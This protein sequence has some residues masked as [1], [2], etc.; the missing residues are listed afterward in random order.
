M[1]ILISSVVAAPPSHGLRFERGS[2]GVTSQNPFQS[3]P[4]CSLSLIAWEHGITHTHTLSLSWCSHDAVF[5]SS[6]RILRCII[7]LFLC[8]CPFFLCSGGKEGGI[9]GEGRAGVKEEKFRRSSPGFS[10]CFSFLFA[11]G[12]ILRPTGTP[13]PPLS[14]PFPACDRRSCSEFQPTKKKQ[15]RESR[16]K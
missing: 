9:R 10:P 14:L 16:K 5:T 1:A 7:F 13:C 4:P 3:I 12:L 6:S 15:K 8:L 11:C 2:G